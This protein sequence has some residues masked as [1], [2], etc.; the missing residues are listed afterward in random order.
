MKRI[1]LS[2]QLFFKQE[3]DKH[4]T[5]TYEDKFLD[6]LVRRLHAAGYS[7]EI[8]KNI[9]FYYNG[10]LHVPDIYLPRERLVIEV[11]G[12]IH[13]T[14]RQTRIDRSRDSFYEKGFK[15]FVYELLNVNVHN[16]NVCDLRLE[17]LLRFIRQSR[18]CKAE[19]EY[20]SKQLEIGRR[21]IEEAFPNI[22][23]GNGRKINVFEKDLNGKIEV[24]K[25]FRGLRIIFLGASAFDKKCS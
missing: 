25:Y 8:Y 12:R 21:S 1:K 24:F 5:T 14:M 7:G 13:E 11:D 4:E 18:E 6:K 22:F 2:D 23:D 10:S 15:V 19:I 9:L 20:A 3:L 16:D 17:K